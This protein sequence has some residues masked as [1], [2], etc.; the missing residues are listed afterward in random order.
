MRISLRASRS[1]ALAAAVIVVVAAAGCN[2]ETSPGQDELATGGNAA[3]GKQLIVHYGCGACHTIG[4]VDA[5]G[6]VGPALTSIKS[7]AY[8]A[9]VLT[10]TPAH[11]EKW[12]MDPTEISP[13]TAMPDLHVGEADAR[14]IVAYLYTQ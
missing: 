7:R 6:K 10:N 9:G 11:L 13:K 4:G 1:A 14:D 3:H 8:I 12:I 2:R 5:I